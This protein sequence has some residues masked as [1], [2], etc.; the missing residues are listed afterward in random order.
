MAH[1]AN[2][3]YRN[4]GRK[5][6]VLLELVEDIRSQTIEIK[7]QPLFPSFPLYLYS[8][9]LCLIGHMNE[10]TTDYFV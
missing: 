5:G 3:D 1:V 7:A 4:I 9:E 8:S 6:R 10:L 2:A